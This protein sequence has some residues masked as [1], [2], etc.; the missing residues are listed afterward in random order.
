MGLDPAPFRSPLTSLLWWHHSSE[1]QLWRTL[2]TLSSCKGFLSYRSPCHCWTC[3]WSPSCLL[4]VSMDASVWHSVWLYSHSP[5]APDIA[6]LLRQTDFLLSLMFMVTDLV[7]VFCIHQN[8]LV[9][10]PTQGRGADGA[11][12]RAGPWFTP[13]E[14]WRFIHV[15]SSGQ[16]V[17]LQHPFLDSHFFPGETRHETNVLSFPHTHTPPTPISFSAGFKMQPLPSAPYYLRQHGALPQKSGH[18]YI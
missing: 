13:W 7:F 18:H 12:E 15:L 10:S 4:K 11:A 1:A 14:C 5:M 8:F 2:V 9:V 16:C 6:R 17:D 3:H